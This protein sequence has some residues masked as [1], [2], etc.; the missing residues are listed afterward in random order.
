MPPM[1]GAMPPMA[2]AEPPTQ[3]PGSPAQASPAQAVGPPDE[4]L[5]RI[6]AGGIPL[7]AEQRLNALRTG[8]AFTSDLSTADFAL[9]HQAGLRPLAQVMG[10]SVYQIGFDPRLGWGGAGGFL[11]GQISELSVLTH[12][13][14]QA[15]MRALDRLAGEAVAVGADA[16][17]GATWHLAQ[18]NFGDQEGSLEYTIV[19]TA[20]RRQS[21]SDAGPQGAGGA[22]ALTDLSVA[23]Y[24][25]LLRAGIEPVGLAGWHSVFFSETSLI[26]GALVQSLA[27]R[28]FRN[29]ELAELTQAIYAARE[30]V[31]E[32]MAAQA[33]ALGASGIVGVQLEHKLVRASSTRAGRNKGNNEMILHFNAFGTA[34]KR[35]GA[36]TPS[37]PT[38]VIDLAS[39]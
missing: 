22:P 35:T 1:A 5:A 24:V 19:G 14:N 37:P 7:A 2:G 33:Q 27:G 38:P 18:I 3:A 11:G 29:F 30:Q 13:Y 23:D 32:R 36:A 9:C 34:I 31:M 6:E 20:V 28:Q 12:A 25:K 39:S 15:R 26:G 4:Q 21:A 17:V 10:T 8:G 16:V